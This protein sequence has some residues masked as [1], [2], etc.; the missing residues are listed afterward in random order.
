MSP[1]PTS[2][3]VHSVTAVA[4]RVSANELSV[5]GLLRGQR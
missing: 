1:F 4:V 3:E 2:S 5:V